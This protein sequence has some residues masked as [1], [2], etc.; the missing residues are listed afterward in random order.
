MQRTRLA[1][2][3]NECG[4]GLLI[5]VN[6]LM[7]CLIFL[8]KPQNSSNFQPFSKVSSSSTS[9]DS[10]GGIMIGPELKEKVK[11]FKSSYE[12]M[13]PEKLEETQKKA[14]H[15]AIN[16]GKQ[17][18]NFDIDDTPTPIS[19]SDTIG[20]NSNKDENNKNNRENSQSLI[21][22]RKDYISQ[23]I[24]N[25][26]SKSQHDDQ[27]EINSIKISNYDR[28][29]F[30]HASPE[31]H[32]KSPLLFTTNDKKYKDI[33]MELL[34]YVPINIETNYDNYMERVLPMANYLQYIN[35]ENENENK[36]E[37]FLVNTKNELYGE[38]TI[39]VTFPSFND[40][41][42][43]ET[44]ISAFGNA[45]NPNRLFFGIYEQN[46]RDTNSN[47]NTK[48]RGNKRHNS[49]NGPLDCLDISGVNCPFHPICSRLWQIS[50]TRVDS[51]EAKGPTW[52]RYMADQLYGKY[53]NETFILI[54]DSHTF[55]RPLWD[56]LLLNLW[57]KTENEYAIISH[58]PKPS[59]AIINDMP[60]W[61]GPKYH[62]LND[63]QLQGKLSKFDE[64]DL[65]LIKTDSK[66]Y[67]DSISQSHPA[68]YHIC[69]SIFEHPDNYMPR[70]AN[71]CY[72][73]L[74][75]RNAYEMES[76][77]V[78]FWAAGFSFSKSH[79]RINVPFDPYTQYVFNGEE[80]HFAT[81]A[82]T[83]GYDFYSP[84]FDIA[85]HRYYGHNTKRKNIND[86]KNKDSNTIRQESEKRIN[87]LW[88]LLELRTPSN[89][90]QA[91]L[92]DIDKYPL[93]RKRSL[94]NYWKFAGIEP[95]SRNITVFKE[96][97]WANGGLKRIPWDDQSIDPVIN[98]HLYYD[99]VL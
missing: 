12:K 75:K 14:I 48:R 72:A 68:S 1:S 4:C 71:G 66:K 57:Y 24:I 59:D 62:S 73:N 52:G 38:E 70:N 60:R 92:I 91:N 41:D 80:F 30:L 25:R 13:T 50:I 37:N 85:F 45:S 51:S 39:F 78:P 36:N 63:I 3:S 76:I 5:C 61:F 2:C 29:P 95:I 81:R 42:C 8:Y 89:V 28:N 65:K 86:I 34:P 15:E 99:A 44:I 84:P 43:N 18:F 79:V 77:L 21:D 96:S 64:N 74:N 6:L 54:T 31:S 87:S 90:N 17:P 20:K 69:G 55:F 82:W 88:G 67:F 23:N 11:R 94:K 83:H 32:S 93:G 97:Q 33:P 35:N 49:N 9:S 27:S 46:D 7:I 58:Y 10:D 40:A 53:G 56:Q 26:K 22:M 19:N 47:T 98:P 16:A